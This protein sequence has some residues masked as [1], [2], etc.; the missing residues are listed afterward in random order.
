MTNLRSA[1]RVLD[2]QELMSI[3]SWSSRDHGARSTV[4]HGIRSRAQ[5]RIRFRILLWPNLP[6]WRHPA[7]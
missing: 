6:S 7:N 2:F 4:A 5:P 3:L 1:P